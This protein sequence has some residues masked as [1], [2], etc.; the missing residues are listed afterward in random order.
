M[1]IATGRIVLDFYNNERATDKNRA[2]EE[3]CKTLRKKFN[4][5][6]LE[7]ADKDDLERG[8]L[9]FAAVC[10]ETWSEPSAER[11]CNEICKEI[12]SISPARVMVEDLII[13]SHGS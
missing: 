3:V 8:V 13:L 5:S 1:W 9:G 12:D 10:P 7:I 11:L 2:L 6:A 4:V